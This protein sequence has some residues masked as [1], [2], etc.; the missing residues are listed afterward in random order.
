MD[1]RVLIFD[2][3]LRDGEQS[4]GAAMTVDEKVEIARQL[5]KLNVDVIEAGFPISSPGDFE[6]VQKIARE[7]RKP[8][9]AALARA[10][11]ADVDR[12]A[13]ALKDAAHPRIHVFISSSDEHIQHQLNK[14]REEVVEMAA[15]NIARAR[16]HVDDVEFSPMDSSRTDKEFL[17]HMVRAAVDAGATTINIPDTVGYAIPEEFA[18]L[19][20]YLREQVPELG[21]TVRLSVH[22]HDD[23]G[24]SVANS[25]AAVKAGARQVEG[26][27]N[28]IG[29]RAGNTA[30]EEIIMALRTRPDY[31]GVDSQVNAKQLFATSRLVSQ[32]S[33]FAVQPNKAIVGRNAFRHASGIHQDAFLKKATT[34]EIIDPVEV[35]VPRSELVLGKLSGR[36]GLMSRLEELGY[37]PTDEELGKIYEAFTSI[38]D[39]KREVTD[40]DLIALMSNER[41]S[42]VETYSLVSVQVT[43]GS[44]AIATA[45]VHLT[46]Q[47]GRAFTDAATG[48]GPVDAVYKAINRLV[49][50]PNSLTDFSVNSVTEGI[51]AVGEVSIRIEQDDRQYIGRGADTD[52]IVASAKAYMNALNRLLSMGDISRSPEAATAV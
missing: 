44:N 20:T 49:L 13:E 7:V 6:A 29:E 48:S 11:P 47:T 33:G 12:A 52:I 8:I 37:T 28:G 10:N 50:V 14:N 1:D 17:A 39:K 19:I 38:A 4:A 25:L 32:V 2:T 51:D 5:E 21:D 45:T 36:H 23:L 41:T 43:C 18:G 31:F 34:F 35:G 30:L 15:Q 3:T 24:M 40:R 27:I 26:C 9:I 46:D 42:V 22:C 16:K